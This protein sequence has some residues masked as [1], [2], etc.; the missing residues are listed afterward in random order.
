[1]LFAVITV[2]RLDNRCLSPDQKVSFRRLRT[3]SG[4]PNKGF[5]GAHHQESLARESGAQHHKRLSGRS[6]APSREGRTGKSNSQTA[7]IVLGTEAQGQAELPQERRGHHKGIRYQAWLAGNK[8]QCWPCWLPGLHGWVVLKDLFRR[9]FG[10]F[11]ELN[12]LLR[13]QWAR[14]K[15]NPIDIWLTPDFYQCLMQCN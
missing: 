1:M 8:T 14:E 4:I 10:L 12:L 5:L 6:G 9:S 3:A 7:N 13:G 15:N 2:C 11:W